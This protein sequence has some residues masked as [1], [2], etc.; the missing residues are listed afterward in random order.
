MFSGRPTTTRSASEL[1]G[2]ADDLAHVG[3]SITAT[4]RTRVPLGSLTAQPILAVP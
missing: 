1:P 2:D 4:G 3:G